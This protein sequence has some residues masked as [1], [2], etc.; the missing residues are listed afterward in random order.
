MKHRNVYSFS[1]IHFEFFICFRMYVLEITFR[2]FERARQESGKKSL[3]KVFANKKK[4]GAGSSEMN[5]VE[6]FALVAFSSSLLIYS[7]N[8]M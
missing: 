1:H 5:R 2:N 3:R 4:G 8:E 6:T 7:N